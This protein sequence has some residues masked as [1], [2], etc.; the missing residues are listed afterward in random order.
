MKRCRNIEVLHLLAFFAFYSGA[1][2]TYS[3]LPKMQNSV[4]F[5]E[6]C[7]RVEIYYL[8]FFLHAERLAKASRFFNEINLHK[9]FILFHFLQSRKFHN[10]H[11]TIISYRILFDISLKHH[12]PRLLTIA[13]VFCFTVSA[14]PELL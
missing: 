5:L 14:S 9:G 4:P 12:C 10:D 3:T 6:V 7:Q 1:V 8:G 13:S 2:P 11:K